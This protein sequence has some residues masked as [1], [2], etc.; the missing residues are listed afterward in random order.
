[1]RYNLI[2]GCKNMGSWLRFSSV[3]V[4]VLTNFAKHLQIRQFHSLLKQNSPN[5]S[6]R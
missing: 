2:G 5:F 1:M 6:K 3:F 4:V